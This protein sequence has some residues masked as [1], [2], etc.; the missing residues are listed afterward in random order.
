VCVCVCVYPTVLICS[1]IEL[2]GILLGV[3]VYTQTHSHVHTHTC[4]H[5]HTHTHVRTHT[6]THTH[7]HTHT[8]TGASKVLEDKLLKL[9]GQLHDLRSS[10]KGFE[11]D[12]DRRLDQCL[13]EILGSCVC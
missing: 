9:K 2:N 7:T 12:F 13:A 3:C 8:Y 1:T 6:R 4:T 11:E 10:I 5:T